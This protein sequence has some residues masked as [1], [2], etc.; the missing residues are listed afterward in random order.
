MSLD[1]KL[2]IEKILSYPLTPVPLSLCHIDGKM[3]NTSK[4]VLLNILEKKCVSE[5]PT[6][7]EVKI[8][9]GF[10]ILHLIKDLPVKFGKIAQK[11]INF[12][13]SSQAM[14]VIITFDM[15]RTPS[16]K[17][18]EHTS[19]GESR[20]NYRI[21]GPE[22]DRPSNFSKALDDISFKE[23]LI[24]YFINEWEKDLYAPFIGKIFF[25][26]KKYFPTHIIDLFYYINF[27]FF[28]F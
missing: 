11:I 3:C 4:S 14:H 7:C 22:Q 25:L 28:F 5:P 6:R 9:D 18:L 20:G 8:F 2:D 24:S 15:Y 12:F 16:I 21:I 13:L 23:A 27:F 19:R 17:D 10:F 26:F 1:N